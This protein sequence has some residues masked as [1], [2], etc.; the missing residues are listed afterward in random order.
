MHCFNKYSY[1]DSCRQN[2]PRPAVNP[3]SAMWCLLTWPTCQMWMSSL[4]ALKLLPI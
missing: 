2:V 3:I 1:L 4:T